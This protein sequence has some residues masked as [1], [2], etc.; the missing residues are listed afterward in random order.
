M[1]EGNKGFAGSAVVLS[2]IL[3]GVVGAALAILYTPLEGTQTRG[4]LKDLTDEMKEKSGHLS[5]EW[6]EKA[7]TFIEKGKEFVEQKR[8][9]LSS[10]FDAGREAMRK[11]KEEMSQTEGV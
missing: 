10:A 8:G 5:E 7:A 2:F 9:I 11:E 4:K 1:S 6:K 3:G